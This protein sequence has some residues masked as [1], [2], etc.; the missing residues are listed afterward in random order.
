MPTT[1]WAAEEGPDIGKHLS[2]RVEGYYRW[3]RSSPVIARILKSFRLMNGLSE[4]GA[5]TWHTSRA[6]V[7]GEL[8]KMRVG[9]FR[10]LAELRVTLATQEDPAWQPVATNSDHS[11]I[12][13]ATSVVG[14]LDYYYREQ[15]VERHLKTALD[16]V[17]WTGEGFVLG[18]WDARKG[19][20][21][22]A[23]PESGEQVKEGDLTFRNP[24]T[25]DVIRDPYASSYSSI[26]WRIVRDYGSKW[27]IAAR[28]PEQADDITGIDRDGMDSADFRVST[29]SPSDEIAVY[30]FFHDKTD[31]MP[32]GRYVIFLD[33]NIILFDGPLP[34]RDNPLKRCVEKELRGTPFGY[35][36]MFEA[37]GPQELTDA[38]TSAIAT[39]QTAG[40]VRKLVGVK[41]SGLNYKQLTQA[42][43]YLEVASMDQMPKPLD[44]ADVSPQVF[45]FR[46]Q[47]I[48]EM[49]QLTSINDIQRGVMN[50]NVKSGA[51]AALYDA[52]ALRAAGPL[53]KAY[54]QL[55][56][57]I[58]TFILHTLTDYAAD[59]ER[60]ARIVGLQNRPL[61][62]A[63]KG[64]D[65]EGFDRVVIEATNHM[66]KT[67]T[68]KQAIAD[69]LLE[70]GAL[71]QGELAGQKYIQVLRTGELEQ[72]LEGPQANALR[73]KRD[74]ELLSKGIGPVPMQPVMDP[75]TGMPVLGPDGQP[76]TQPAPEPGRQ[77][78]AIL[79]C[80]SHWIDIPEY[81]SV[82]SSPEARE[83]PEVTGAVFDA[84]T[85]KLDMWR[86]MDPDLLAVMG[87]QPPPSMAMPPQG[88][89]G[90]PGGTQPPS[91][92]E[93]SATPNPNGPPQPADSTSPLPKLP[94]NP[95]TGQNHDT[96]SG[97]GLV[98]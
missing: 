5:S 73:I 28:Y 80:D 26:S 77:Y 48:Q 13:Q 67:V 20:V 93:Q 42:L 95:A 3:C 92:G 65:L 10:N 25:L 45:Q 6:G 97:G 9:H 46:A 17:Q 55:A 61:L 62:Y 18:G 8:V 37:L 68:G 57:D 83:S 70:K 1:Y 15:R 71:G 58:G 35:T 94:K 34:Y 38:L 19:R 51:H 79:A 69:A 33:S 40:A 31:A 63:F 91:R 84:V 41:G 49:Q 7:Q 53:Q 12:A 36:A 90:P 50:A 47:L 56:E 87:G 43:G 88:P 14:L 29:D 44:F 32:N 21:V 98:Q 74:K 81:L 82:L 59:S 60:T 4:K 86:S 75:L 2:E 96:E 39:Q 30:H 16:D 11:S 85:R 72:L 54:Y 22:A 89:M 27:D 76:E 66:G 52:I 24:N 23:D 64:A 78:L